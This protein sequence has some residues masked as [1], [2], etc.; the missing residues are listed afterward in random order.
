MP[1]QYTFFTKPT[2]EKEQ[3]KTTGKYE[4]NGKFTH[5][6]KDV[7]TNLKCQIVKKN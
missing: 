7:E 3:S 6:Y 1:T 4:K 2:S 5:P